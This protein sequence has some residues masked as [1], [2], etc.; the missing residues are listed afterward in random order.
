MC[1][2]IFQP[3]RPLA[4][5]LNW[6]SFG[7]S[8]AEVLWMRRFSWEKKSIYV[9]NWVLCPSPP[10]TSV[11]FHWQ[12]SF[13]GSVTASTPCE[14]VSHTPAVPSTQSHHLCVT[15]VS[16][17]RQPLCWFQ[18]RHGLTLISQALGLYS[19][20]FCLVLPF[21]LSLCG[22][23]STIDGEVPSFLIFTTSSRFV[24]VDW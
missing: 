14:C 8:E 19:P 7:S 18:I 24:F 13:S 23:W 5:H 17:D 9:L 11:R 20:C 4:P 3:L 22:A 10:P 16:I 6:K 21:P 12:Q 15:S 1:Y 2:R